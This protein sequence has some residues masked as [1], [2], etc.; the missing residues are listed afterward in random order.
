MSMNPHLSISM[1]SLSFD[2]L[3]EVITIESYIWSIKLEVGDIL[4]DLTMLD[5]SGKSIL[6]MMIIQSISSGNQILLRLHA[7]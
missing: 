5:I 1:I 2:I 3:M 6:L 7:Q 4:L